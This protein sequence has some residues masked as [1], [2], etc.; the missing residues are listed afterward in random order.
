MFKEDHLKMRN[1][2]SEVQNTQ[3][4]HLNYRNVEYFFK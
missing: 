1:T 3:N 2:K 4:I